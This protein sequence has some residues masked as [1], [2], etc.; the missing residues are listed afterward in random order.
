MIRLSKEAREA[1]RQA[2]L[3]ARSLGQDTVQTEHLLIGLLRCAEQNTV[4][5]LRRSGAREETLCAL[6]ERLRG[7]GEGA[8]L[9]AGRMSGELEQVVQHS[10]ALARESG[11]VEIDAFC[12]LCSLLED[13]SSE[14][15]E[16]WNG[17]EREPLRQAAQRRLQD[18]KVPRADP[19]KRADTPFLNRYG[20]DLTAMA[21][22]GRLDEAAGREEEMRQ[23]VSILLRRRKNNPCL[24]GPP[25]VGKTAIVEGF[26]IQLASGRVPAA[27][28]GK[29]LVAL[30]LSGMLAGAKYRGEFEERVKGILNELQKVDDVILFLDELHTVVGAGA[31]EGAID[32]ANILK[33]V[34]ARGQMRLIGATTID[35]YHRWIEKD[36]ALERRLQQITVHEP[37]EEQAVKMLMSLRAGLER[38]HGV[39]IPDDAVHRAVEWSV[40]Y[41]PGRYLPDKAVDL[42]DEAACTLRLDRETSTSRC[43]RL[44]SRLDQLE[45]ERRHAEEQ[46]DY[47]QAACLQANCDSLLR[48]LQT[49]ERLQE[50]QVGEEVLARVL[51]DRTGIPCER[52]LGC[53]S[54]KPLELEQR[55]AQRVFGQPR[56]VAAVAQAV[57]RM[58]A[59]LND[60]AHPL[61]SLLFLGPSGVGKTELARALCVELF[62]REKRLIRLDL[63]EYREPHSIS[64]LIG[65]PPGYAGCDRGGLLTDQLRQTPACVLLFDEAEKAHPDVINLLLQILEEGQLTDAQGRVADT[66]HAVVILTSNL[67]AREA[68]GLGHAGFTRAAQDGERQAID[69]LKGVFAPELLGRIEQVVVFEPLSEEAYQKIAAYQLGKL[70]ERLAHRGIRLRFAGQ[71]AQRLCERM[72]HREQGARELKTLLLKLIEWP[73]T[74]EIAGRSMGEEE[75]EAELA[76]D[77]VLK[78]QALR[79]AGVNG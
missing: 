35:E 38:H 45:L 27:L 67:G 32:A 74:Q 50:Q 48:Q 70:E 5:L 58:D 77:G 79:P 17:I 6:S 73:L 15:N 46:R 60:T 41:W 24:I 36:A 51:C 55:L 64:R 75:W 4:G 26:A 61:G 56:A 14:E 62:G 10:A 3:C 29:R 21:Y 53:S 68:L 13:N 42:L 9:P 43:T 33:P 72:A 49:Q 11:R 59:G 8:M 37:D 34:L 28:R 65:A 16:L 39:R 54:R 78:L 71:T 25:G 7:R 66:R 69:A 31:A 19:A 2:E 12:L 44:Q 47:L 23:L 63:S 30:D 20:V 22:A 57:A 76:E 40:R 52:I 1:I 18:D